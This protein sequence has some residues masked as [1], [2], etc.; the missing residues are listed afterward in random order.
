MFYV[1]IE[2]HLVHRFEGCNNQPPGAD[3]DYMMVCTFDEAISEAKRR[4]YNRA[5]ICEYCDR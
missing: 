3:R 1:N 5:N 2:T 4:G